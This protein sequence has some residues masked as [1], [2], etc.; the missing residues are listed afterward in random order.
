L[1]VWIET[2]NAGGMTFKKKIS[3]RHALRPPAADAALV[4]IR[5][6]EP[7]ALEVDAWEASS[8]ARTVLTHINREWNALRH[9]C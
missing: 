2:W 5:D 8:A 6:D 9:A 1:D 7:T 3:G 4:D